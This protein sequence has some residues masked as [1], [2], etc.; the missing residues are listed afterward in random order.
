MSIIITETRLLELVAI[1]NMSA[2]KA[3]AQLQALL[4]I[5][6]QPRILLDDGTVRIEA[7]WERNWR[8]VQKYEHLFRTAKDAVPADLS[9][10]YET[11]LPRRLTYCFIFGWTPH[12][13]SY[14]M[15]RVEG[16]QSLSVNDKQ[17]LDK[18]RELSPPIEG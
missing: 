16:K 6:V 12:G 13:N 10:Y 3:L 14:W 5:K 9:P 2:I 15:D 4:T 7:P 17:Y 18:M 11:L 8:L 1:G